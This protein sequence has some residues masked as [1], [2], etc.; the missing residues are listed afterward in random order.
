MFKMAS[1][2]CSDNCPLHNVAMIK[3]ANPKGGGTFYGCSSFEKTGCKITWSRRDGW[4]NLPGKVRNAT[5]LSSAGISFHEKALCH[6]QAQGF[7]PDEA[8]SFIADVGLQAALDMA[9]A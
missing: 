2:H 6:L 5:K 1:K 9:A 3:R 4:K 8:A 7:A